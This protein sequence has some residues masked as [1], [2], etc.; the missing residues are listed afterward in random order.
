[1]QSKQKQIIVSRYTGT[2]I[3]TWKNK[4]RD[5]P[6]VTTTTIQLYSAFLCATRLA[7]FVFDFKFLYLFH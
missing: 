2:G 5:M 6:I 3:Y 7:I 1:M 4:K